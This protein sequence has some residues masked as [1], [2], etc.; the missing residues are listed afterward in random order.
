MTDRKKCPQVLLFPNHISLALLPRPSRCSSPLGQEQPCMLML[1]EI[2]YCVD[3]EVRK[4]LWWACAAKK[5]CNA[6]D[7]VQEGYWGR[8][9]VKGYPGQPLKY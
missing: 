8:G 1:T 7:L 5:A 3:K 6:T 9:R 2:H 4:H